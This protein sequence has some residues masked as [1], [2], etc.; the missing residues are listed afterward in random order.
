LAC[1]AEV[2]RPL[3]VDPQ[4]GVPVLLFHA[5]EEGVA[6]DAGVVDQVVDPAVG[7]GHGGR[8]AVGGRGVADVGVAGLGPAAGLDDGP[9]HG[10]ELVLLD[11][12][13]DDRRALG[14]ELAG[15]GLADPLGG[16]GDEGDPAFEE[17]HVSLPLNARS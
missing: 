13:Q 3:E 4:H 17:L 15:D 2:E 1:P 10:L 6:G 7:R 8:D 12:D 9:G 11:V 5:H 14:R 16:P